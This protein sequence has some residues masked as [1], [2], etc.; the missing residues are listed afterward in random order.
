LTSGPA[1]EHLACARVAS[2]ELLGQVRS[3]VSRIRNVQPI[4]LRAMLE[5]LTES[6]RGVLDVRLHIPPDLAVADP[7]RAET[8]VR[9]VQEVITNTMRHAQARELVIDVRHAGTG[10]SITARDDGRGG[11]FAAGSGLSGMRE[12]FEMLGGSLSISSRHGEGFTIEGNLP[13]VGS[14]P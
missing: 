5:K 4:N 11:E 9:C 10:I 1:A 8:V 14:L 13:V 3:V 12:R 7:A 6:A 2:G